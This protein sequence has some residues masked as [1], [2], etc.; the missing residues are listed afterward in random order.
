MGGGVLAMK[1]T[2][3]TVNSITQRTE[4]Q[5]KAILKRAAFFR[6]G[7]R[8]RI[9]GR[10]CRSTNGAYLDGWY[11]DE[12]DSRIYPGLPKDM[13]EDEELVEKVEKILNGE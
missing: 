8:D 3:V 2:P 1:S 9:Y 6:A 11:A 13:E 4:N 7:V 12:T 10:P 5:R